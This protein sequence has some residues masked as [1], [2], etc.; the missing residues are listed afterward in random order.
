MDM[1]SDLFSIFPDGF[2]PITH[3]QT[4]IEAGLAMLLLADYPKFRSMASLRASGLSVPDV[5]LVHQLTPDV[6]CAV[7]DF[8]CERNIEKA[9]LRSDRPGGGLGST[10]LQGVPN[11]EVMSQ[12]SN[13]LN[14]GERI[15]VAVQAAGNV[16]RNLYNFNLVVCRDLSCRFVIEVT[17]P[18]FTATD[19]NR[20]GILHE[21][22]EFPSHVQ[23]LS[24][25][26]I[27]R[28]YKVPDALYRAHCQTKVH[29]YGSETLDS[30]DALVLKY[31]QYIPTPISY[32][33]EVW[34]E[35]ESIYQVIRDMGYQ[36]RGAILSLSFMEENNNFIRHYYWDIHPLDR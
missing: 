19:L 33:E 27:S 31:P 12:I 8:L 10:S 26:L 5:L 7:Q 9:L 2:I 16:F 22:I 28:R 23:S 32:L 24:E 11:T 25:S 14:L 6:V 3:Q 1:D 30:Q 35:R 18:G 21:R 4:R 34:A 36:D 20:Y 17:G 29:K 13:L 15:L